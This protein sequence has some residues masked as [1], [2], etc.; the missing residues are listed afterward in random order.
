MDD[1]LGFRILSL[2]SNSYCESY[3]LKWTIDQLKNK[4][5]LYQ[6]YILQKIFYFLFLSIIMVNTLLKS[7]E[8]SSLFDLTARSL[9][10]N[11]N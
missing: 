1:L 5:F 2:D 9:L 3:K 4:M 10:S 7:I 8:Y 6:K 11:I